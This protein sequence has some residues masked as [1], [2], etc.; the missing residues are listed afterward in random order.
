MPSQH[1]KSLKRLWSDACKTMW[2]QTLAL[3]HLETGL[4]ANYA[5]IGPDTSV[6]AI[7]YSP[8][9]RDRLDDAT[10]DFLLDRIQYFI[11]YNVTL[12]VVLLSSAFESYFS[13]FLEDYL[14]NRKKYFTDGSRTSEGNKVFGEIMKTRGIEERVRAFSAWTGSKIKSLECRLGVLKDVYLL[15]NLIAHAAGICDECT[16]ERVNSVALVPGTPISIT[17]DA[18]VQKLAPPCIEIAEALDKKIRVSE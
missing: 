15:R 8:E 17:P 3:R 2:V 13:A 11:D 4:R 1:L 7:T 9:A 16:A 18:L 5:E 10:K 14:N 6:A 12:R